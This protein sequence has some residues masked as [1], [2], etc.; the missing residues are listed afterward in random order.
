MKISFIILLFLI[1]PG[2]SFSQQS[3]PTAE[4]THSDYMKKSKVQKKTSDVLLRAG[5]IL[6]LTGAIIVLK[7]TI[8]ALNL[9]FVEDKK[10]SPAGPILLSI[11]TISVLCSIPFSISSNRNKKKGLSFS[12]KNEK[13]SMVKNGGFVNRAVPSL[14]LKIML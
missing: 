10:L 12:I 9:I 11:G 3:N 4:V 1:V 14:T 8:D 5:V 13:V 2:I 7:E 6:D